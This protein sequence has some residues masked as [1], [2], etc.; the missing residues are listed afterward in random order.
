MG[1]LIKGNEHLNYWVC[2]LVFVIL[3]SVVLWLLSYLSVAGGTAAAWIGLA[4][5]ILLMPYISGRLVDYISD[6]W[7]D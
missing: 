1:K 2:G 5:Y 4:L 6:Q 7:M 3:Y